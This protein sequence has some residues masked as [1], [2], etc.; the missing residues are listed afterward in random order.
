F[1]DETQQNITIL[2]DRSNEMIINVTAWLD[3]GSPSSINF[4]LFTGSQMSS[5]TNDTNPSGCLV[6]EIVSNETIRVPLNASTTYYF[7]FDNKD[8]S[9]SRIVL[10]SAS[11]FNRSVKTMVIRDG[12]INFVDIV[13][14]SVGF[15]VVLYGL[16]FR[17]D[18]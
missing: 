8:S 4:K 17:S 10:F 3:S 2:P 16:V 6:N 14:V 15:L 5:C 13:Y 1:Q 12:V 11:L 18:V 7:V 9:S